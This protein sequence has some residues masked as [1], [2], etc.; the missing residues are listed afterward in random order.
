MRELELCV[1]QKR[2]F[3]M[4]LAVSLLLLALCG[5]AWGDMFLHNARGSNNR[6]DETSRPRINANRCAHTH[7][8]IET[9]GVTS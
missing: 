7:R 2:L 6:L 5:L 3:S 8:G 9:V 4:H 1:Y